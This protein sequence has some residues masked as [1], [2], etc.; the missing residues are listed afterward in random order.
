L[1]AILDGARWLVK[2][3]PR[4]GRGIWILHVS[5]TYVLNSR[6][7]T[8]QDESKL[9]AIPSF[10]IGGKKVYKSDHLLEY[11]YNFWLN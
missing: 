5:K 7:Y 11:K 1:V 3:K 6:K 2:R 10:N 8:I 9:I 4:W